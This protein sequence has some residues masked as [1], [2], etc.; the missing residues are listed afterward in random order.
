MPQMPVSSLLLTLTATG[1]CAAPSP[2]GLLANFQASPA[3]GVTATPTL[4]W[5]QP[6][7]A[8][9][10]DHTQTSYRIIV[11]DASHTCLNV[12]IRPTLNRTRTMDAVTQGP[13][14][15]P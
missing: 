7:A 8:N 6:P 11:T 3:L 14:C 12:P 9:A 13:S 4:S 5:V 10:P 15:S 2:Y 1:V